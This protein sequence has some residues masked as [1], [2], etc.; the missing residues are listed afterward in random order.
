VAHTLALLA[1]TILLAVGLAVLIAAT[2]A[3]WRD[4]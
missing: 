1:L 2:I 3:I 4:R